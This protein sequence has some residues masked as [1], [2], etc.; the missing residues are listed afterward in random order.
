M[1]R[2]SNINSDSLIPSST[3][4]HLTRYPKQVE[5]SHSAFAVSYSKE[6]FLPVREW[7]GHE[8]DEIIISFT[9]KVMFVCL[10]ADEVPPIDQNSRWIE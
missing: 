9:F 10:F 6:G 5:H 4:S 8:H 1:I 7:Q 3:M 2:D